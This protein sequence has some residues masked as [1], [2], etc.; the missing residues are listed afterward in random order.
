MREI[1]EI[2]LHCSASPN[3]KPVPAATI[4]EWHKGRGWDGI[5][6]NKVIQPDG[7]VEEG[8]PDYWVPSQA[9]GHNAHAIGV[10]LIGLNAFTEE[11]WQ[12]LEQVARALHAKFPDAVFRG[13][14]EVS[15]KTCPNFD[16]AAWAH[17][18]GLPR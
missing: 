5:G 13:H 7:T 18:L 3:F 14:Y 8:R 12:S 11:Q 15:S 17:A 2:F 9:A 6:Y 4:H 10:C 16:V 1:K